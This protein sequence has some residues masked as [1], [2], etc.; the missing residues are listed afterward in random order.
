MNLTVLDKDIK[1][2]RNA[3]YIYLSDC[4]SDTLVIS[5]D[6]LPE[7][8]ALIYRVRPQVVRDIV[9]ENCPEHTPYHLNERERGHYKN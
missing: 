9:C 1:P 2:I 8:V 5:D 6:K 3:G 7:L 4:C